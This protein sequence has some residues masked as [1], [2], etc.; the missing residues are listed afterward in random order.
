MIPE[1]R[2]AKSGDVNIAY[3]ILGEGPIDLVFVPGWVSHVEFMWE[4]PRQARFLN[5]LASF[6]RLLLFD[7]RGVGLSDRVPVNQLPI[8]EERIGDVRAVMDAAGSER[9]AL[10]GVSEGGAMSALFA[11]T[12]PERTLALVLYGAFARAGA[13]LL[14]S[15]EFEESLRAIEDG[16]PDSIDPAL[17][18]PS[19]SGDEAY[20]QWFRSF[21]RHAA[22]PGAAVALHRMNSQI[23]ICEVLSAIH[24]PTLVLYRRDARF[25]HGAG[26]WRAVGEDLITPADEAAVI[27]RRVAGARVMELPGIDHLP[28][29]GD[30]DSVLGEVEEFL[31]G[32]RRGPEPDR[33][34][35][36]I[37]FTD[38][39][40]STEVAARVGD[41]RW[42]DLVERHNAVVR[43]QLERFGGREIDTA[44]DGFFASF[45]GPA[46]GIRCA[47]AIA[48]SVTALGLE[49]RAGL[50][51]GE[52][53]LIDGKLAG[54]AVHIAARVAALASPG[55]VLVS[56]TVKDLVVGS[57]MAFRDHGL[58]ALKGVPGEW[59]VFAVEESERPG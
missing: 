24:V 16:W 18:A 34:L 13:R 38:I 8:L 47:R 40:E 19:L 17:P 59:R 21:L 45:D 15:T 37:L 14:S 26:A 20:R 57:R 42:R 2:Y 36:T 43:R 53:E 46:T 44:G 6:S 28:W 32:V 25:G 39:I 10:F 49:I 29:V 54:I 1:T 23:D 56:G 22:S 30:A 41:E 4:D 33:V 11:A 31:T 50:H 55:E 7:K 51:T 58:Q 9:A 52:C 27:G 35:A 5:R 3:Q 48:E 12:H